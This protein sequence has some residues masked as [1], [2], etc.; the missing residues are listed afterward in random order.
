LALCGPTPDVG[1][2]FVAVNLAISMCQIGIKTLLMDADLRT[3][4]VQNYF[5]DHD[6]S[7]G[8]YDCLARGVHITDACQADVLPNLDVMFAGT[9]DPEGAQELL[10]SE[11]FSET[12]N[13]CLRDYDVT[14]I[15]TPAASG[16]SDSRL[17]SSVVGFSLVVARKNYSL[18][19]D[20][21]TL[22]AEIRRAKASVVGS[23]LNAF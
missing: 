8:L 3:P 15:D 19:S 20:V 21:Q 7:V 16:C 6:S 2:T 14:I 4:S 9:A 10:A 11:H 12:V 13:A 18:V 1:T 22:S 17:I 23:V 5:E